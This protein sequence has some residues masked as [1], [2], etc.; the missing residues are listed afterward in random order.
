[1][2][3]PMPRNLLIL[4]LC[5][6]GCVRSVP[7][8]SFDPSSDDV[9][10]LRQAGPAGLEAL[11]AR[12]DSASEV[13]RARLRPLIDQVARQRDAWVSRLFWYDDVER[14]KEAAAASGRPILSLRM[15]GKLDED[16]SCANSRF[17]RT[18]LYANAELSKYLREHFVLHWSSERPVPVLT[19]DYGDGRKVV[20]TVTGNSIH[21]VLDSS[22]RV[23]DALPGLYGPAAFRAQLELAEAAAQDTAEL[24]D[25]ER[26]EPVRELHR[27]ALIRASGLWSEDATAAGHGQLSGLLPGYSEDDAREARGGPPSALRA[28]PIAV[29][30]AIVEA[31][32]IERFVPD[33]G[34]SAPVETIPWASI[35]A[36]RRAQAALDPQS[37]ALIAS[38][39]PRDWSAQRSPHLE[40]DGLAAL[41]EKFT[42]DIAADTAKNEYA[43]HS[44]LHAWLIAAP[45]AP[46]AALNER[47]YRELFLTPKS[48]AWL[49][50]MPARAFSG[51]PDDGFVPLETSSR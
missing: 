7:S 20:R 13:E 22:G 48:D 36:R 41:A 47:V 38:K 12:Y 2:K 44:R 28:V 17:F 49:G 11:L 21:Y 26:V 40:E 37:R 27:V 25:S 45:N 3:L 16:L 43:L 33:G 30:K 18:A 6:S 51:L 34:V 8:A 5:V 4:C 50:L 29:T 31:P 46:L 42:D 39:R 10:A 15:L 14:A 9:D 19:I 35:G 1:L 23:V 24:S 32:V